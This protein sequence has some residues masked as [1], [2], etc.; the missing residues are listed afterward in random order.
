MGSIYREKLSLLFTISYLATIK[1]R[2]QFRRTTAPFIT[3]WHSK[4]PNQTIVDHHLPSS[5]L[6]QHYPTSSPLGQHYPTSSSLSQYCPTSSPLSQHCPTS[7][8]LGQHWSAY[9]SCQSL[10][11]TWSA[12][13]A[14]HLATPFGMDLDSVIYSPLLLDWASLISRYEIFLQHPD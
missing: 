10:L 6:S 7:S 14:N 4:L 3:N 9:R 13:L 5:S 12:D 1:L 2:L 11:V 8:P